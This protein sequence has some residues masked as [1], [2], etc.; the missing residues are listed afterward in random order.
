MPPRS[1]QKRTRANPPTR[2]IA[3]HFP[4][5]PAQRTNKRHADGPGNVVPFPVS[6]RL[7]LCAASQ[8]GVSRPESSTAERSAA[9]G[10][11]YL[12]SEKLDHA[13]HLVVQFE[14]VLQIEPKI[15]AV[16]DGVACRHQAVID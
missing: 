5:F 6:Q 15:F 13:E 14:N 11:I 16:R 12:I 9:Y 8:R 4:Q 10:V 2:Q 3:P 7:T 1:A